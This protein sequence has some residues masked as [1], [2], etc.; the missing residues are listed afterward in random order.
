MASRGASTG[1]VGGCHV[2]RNAGKTHDHEQEQRKGDDDGAIVAA[3]P[4]DE[5]A[6]A[7]RVAAST[8]LRLVMIRRARC[9]PY[10]G[11]PYEQPL[12]YMLT[13]NHNNDQSVV[14]LSVR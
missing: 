7:R 3:R 8:C 9:C 6:P 2:D 10:D 13:D 14:L 12:T 11:A 5:N 4:C 1:A